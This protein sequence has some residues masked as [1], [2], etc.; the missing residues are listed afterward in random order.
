[1]RSISTRAWVRARRARR[2]RPCSS[3]TARSAQSWPTAA[4][5]RRPALFGSSPRA[6]GTPAHQIPGAA[7]ARFIPTCVGNMSALARRLRRDGGSSP[8]AWG[9]ST[10]MLRPC[11]AMSVHPHVRG[12]HHRTVRCPCSWSS[13]HPHVCGEH[14][15]A[16]DTSRAISRF[17]PTCV[18]N[19]VS[20]VGSAARSSVH[21]HVCG[22]HLHALAGSI[23][24]PVHPHVCGE[25]HDCRARC[26]VATPV[27]PHVCGEHCYARCLALRQLRF[28][29]TCVGNIASMTAGDRADPVHPH[30]CGEHLDLIVLLTRRSGSS[31]RVWGTST[32]CPHSV[33]CRRFIPTCVGNMPMPMHRCDHVS[34]FIPTCV[35]NMHVSACVCARPVHPHVCGEHASSRRMI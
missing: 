22:E 16:V 32:Q 33:Q 31:P 26:N 20:I 28:I 27:H 3:A 13:V 8:R 2:S 19:I 17:I 21:P 25:H 18:G 29:P 10:R 23:V 15:Y 7:P 35:G 4:Y 24:V 6:W 1:M 11:V 12:E 34:R 14:R 9:T 5:R 30:V